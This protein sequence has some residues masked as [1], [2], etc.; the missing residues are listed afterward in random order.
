VVNVPGTDDWYIVYHRRPL[1]DDNGDHR[2]LAIDR[3]TFNADGT[4]APVVMTNEGIAPRPLP[5]AIEKG[6]RS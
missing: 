6:R 2:Q 1:H 4:I 5:A 3:M